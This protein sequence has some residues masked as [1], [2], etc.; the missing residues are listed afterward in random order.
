MEPPESRPLIASLQAKAAWV[1]RRTLQFHRACPDTRIASSLSLVE[2]FTCLFYGGLLKQ[3][4]ER[5]DH[6]DRDRLI[7]SKG[8]GSIAMYPILGDLGYFD[9]GLLERPEDPD[10]FLGSIPDPMIP[11]YE[12]VNGSLGHG[13][14]IACGIAYALKVQER[15]QNVVVVAGDGELNEGSVWEAVMFAAHHQL[16]NLTMILD[17]NRKSMLGLCADIVQLEPLE[18][19]FQG[20]GWEAQRVDGHDVQAVQ[21]ALAQV[22]PKRT[23]K[24]KL[25]IA[26]TVKGHGVPELERDDLCHIRTLSPATLDA[27]LEARP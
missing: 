7:I 20:F 4:P 12:T 18:P 5:L 1:W 11:G 22:L 25:L 10:A 6:P 26:D 24:P 21:T 3:F 23:G 17:N 27:L 8:H 14:G 19:R 13:P 15:P 9:L 16:D 2:V